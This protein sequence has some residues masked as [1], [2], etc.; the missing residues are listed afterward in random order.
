MSRDL[1]RLED[2]GGSLDPDTG[3]SR[4]RRGAKPR[5]VLS[6]ILCCICG[7]AIQPNGANMCGSC[8]REQVDVTEGIPKTG[9]K[10]IQCR[11]CERW[12]TKNDHWSH[13]ELE[14]APFLALTLKKIPGLS[15][16]DVVDARWIWTGEVVLHAFDDV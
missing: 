15:K 16:Q 5:P 6:T 11:R 8:L 2:M 4:I 1:T 3:S 14:S 12:L 10:M 13:F 9:L 7:S